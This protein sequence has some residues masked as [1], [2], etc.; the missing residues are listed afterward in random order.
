MSLY[1]DIEGATP[2][3]S[4]NEEALRYYTKEYEALGS[5]Y[6]QTGDQLYMSSLE[7]D[8]G[9]WDHQIV[10]DDMDRLRVLSRNIAMLNYLISKADRDAK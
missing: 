10:R 9:K 3:F 2:R 6:G 1:S 7:Q 5:K 8:F 4:S